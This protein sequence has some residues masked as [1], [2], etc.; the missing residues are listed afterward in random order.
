MPPLS[1][2]E[3]FYLIGVIAAFG[4]FALTLGVTNLIL[5]LRP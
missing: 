4:G 2:P 3:L 1:T 5:T